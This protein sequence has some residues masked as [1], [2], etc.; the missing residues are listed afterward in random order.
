MYLLAVIILTSFRNHYVCVVWVCKIKTHMVLVLP[1]YIYYLILFFILN[2]KIVHVQLPIKPT[3]ITSI[4]L[5][6][7]LVFFLLVF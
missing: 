5:H 4:L 3:H 2:M 7:S 6:S 1:M